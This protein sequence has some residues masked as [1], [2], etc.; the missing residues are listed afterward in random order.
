MT[1]DTARTESK[2]RADGAAAAADPARGHQRVLVIRHGAL[3]DFVQSLGPMKAI[4]DFHARARITLLTTPAL[5]D[6]A[7]GSGYFDEIRVDERAAGYHVLAHFSLGRRL[8]KVKFDRVYDLQ[9][10]SRTARY[11][12]LMGQ[13]EW[14]GYVPGCSHPDP[15]PE[16]DE[17]HTIDRQRGQLAG[18]GIHKVPLTDL[19]W[20]VADVERFS[21]PRPYALIVPGGAAHRPEK[22]WPA[23]KYAALARRMTQRHCTPVLIGSAAEREVMDEI[24]H[25]NPQIVNLCGETSLEDIVVL[26]RRA[27]GAVGNDTGPMHLI[28]MAGCPSLVLFS[29]DSNPDLCA[30]RPGLLGGQVK[31]IKRENLKG[32]SS[33]EVEAALPFK[34]VGRG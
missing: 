1:Q 25:G 34:L 28:A 4:R 6:F 32:L 18:A 12:R 21:I 22:R 11:W 10:S 16:R 9:T 2:A 7:R 31:T 5:A 14:S 15:D 26:A 17:K 30:P 33:D 19:G 13:P 24:T 29:K 8:R 20:V 3:G 23:E 27:I